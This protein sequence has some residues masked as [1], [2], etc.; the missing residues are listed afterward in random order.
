MFSYYQTY[1][2]LI[3]SLFSVLKM[4]QKEKTKVLGHFP[5]P[6]G[7]KQQPPTYAGGSPNDKQPPT[8]AGGSPKCGRE[9]CTIKNLKP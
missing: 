4:S 8:Y 9:F 2:I 6:D 7:T 5:N 3:L 1:H